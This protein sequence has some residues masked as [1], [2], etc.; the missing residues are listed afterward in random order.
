MA[1]EDTTTVR[2]RRPD[3][4]RLRSMARE[5]HTTVIDVLHAAVDAL[6][7]RD[8]QLGLNQ[9]YQRLRADPELWQQYLAERQE[10]DGLA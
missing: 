2:V 7:R 4:E 5:R 6:E 10:W 8:F 3:S 1:S 9:D